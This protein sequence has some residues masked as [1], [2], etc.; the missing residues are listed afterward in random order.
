MTQNVNVVGLFQDTSKAPL[1]I[2]EL[3]RHGFSQDS[4]QL[5]NSQSAG[6]NLNSYI[7]RLGAPAE[8]A[9]FWARGVQSGGTLLTLQT[10]ENRADEAIDIMERFGV[11]QFENQNVQNTTGSAAQAATRQSA[12][13][14]QGEVVIPI[15]EE[16]IQVGKRQVERGGV[17]IYSRVIE[18]PVEESV[19]LREEEVH[20]ERRPVNRAVTDADLAA[21]KE[22]AIEMTETAEQAV[23]S[24][25]ARVVEEVVVGKETTQHTETVRDTVRRTDVQ[26]EELD[27]DDE[28]TLNTSPRSGVAERR[29]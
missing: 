26:V 19:T 29:V 1:V 4:I 11:A 25:Q 20:V 13:S 8:E 17:R 2:Q 24:K 27:A 3:V 16:Q 9:Q 21:V 28:S 14:V 5:I 12:G 6:A 23:V 18:T 22:G 15:V 10:T 7:T